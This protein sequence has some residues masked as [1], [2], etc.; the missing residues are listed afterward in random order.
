M[1]CL[2]GPTHA[3]STFRPA[4]TGVWTKRDSTSC[5]SDA[6]RVR[7]VAVTSGSK[8]T[9]HT[10]DIHRIAV[11]AHAAG[12]SSRLEYATVASAPIRTWFTGWV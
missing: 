7:L 10:P 9:G 12:P 4:R 3:S 2:G 5:L 6:G 1:I 11:K 8:V